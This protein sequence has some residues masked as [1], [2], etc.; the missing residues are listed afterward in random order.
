[1]YDYLMFRPLTQGEEEVKDLEMMNR[2]SQDTSVQSSDCALL[3]PGVLTV[4]S[5]TV[6]CQLPVCGFNKTRMATHNVPYLR[7][8]FVPRL[9]QRIALR[10]VL[11]VFEVGVAVP[12]V[13]DRFTL[14]EPKVAR[15]LVAVALAA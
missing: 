6:I 9:G 4:L 14:P 3:A 7:H 10:I 5:V 12:C 15:H 11:V 8:P 1:M 13:I 2:D